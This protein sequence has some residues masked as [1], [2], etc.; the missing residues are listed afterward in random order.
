VPPVPSKPIDVAS[1]VASCG[2]R[3]ECEKLCSNGNG[4]A[5]MFAGRLYEYGRDGAPDVARAFSL[6]ERS[7]ALTYAGGCYNAALLYEE[8]RGVEK[9][10]ARARELYQNVCAAGSRTACRRAEQMR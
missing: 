6:Y 5:C 9:N 7:C 1:A 3:A 10:L 8:G 4:G 2:T